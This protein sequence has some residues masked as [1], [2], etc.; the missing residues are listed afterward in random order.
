MSKRKICFLVIML[1]IINIFVIP[2]KSYGEPT[3]FITKKKIK[4][5]NIDKVFTI[6]FSVE[7][8]LS[9]VNNKYF[10]VTDDKGHV[11]NALVKLDPKDKRI[12]TVE[13][14]A[15]YK[16]GKT[17]TITVGKGVKSVDGE[18]LPHGIKIPFET[19]NFYAGLPAE[20]GLIIIGNEAYSIEYIA[21]NTSKKNEILKGNYKVFYIDDYMK[22]KIKDVLGFGYVDGT[23]LPPEY[24]FRKPLIYIDPNGERIQYIWDSDE[25]EFKRVDPEIKI[26]TTINAKDPS[27]KVI[28]VKVK[29]VRWLEGVEYFKTGKSSSYYKIDEAM[30]FSSPDSN[31]KIT[32]FSGSMTKIA[33]AEFSSYLEGTFVRK[34]K[35]FDQ[36]GEGNS[37]GNIVNN[38]YVASD[39]NGYIFYNN[40][41]DK[42]R[43]Y[44][45]DTNGLFHGVISDDFA[46]YINVV[47][48]WIYYSNY[49]DKAKL[50]RM[51]V[52]G[53]YK[54]KLNDE[55]SAFITIVGDYVYYSNYSD[56][57]RITRIRKDGSDATEDNKGNK[58]GHPLS[59]NVRDEAFFLN[60][61]GEW[62]YYSNINDHHRV[63]AVNTSGTYRK[64][65]SDEGASSIQVVDDWIYYTNNKG[66]LRK[67][68]SDGSKETQDLN[69]V[70]SKFERGYFFN[71]VDDWIYYSNAKDSNRLY[72][73]KTDG[74]QNTRLTF[75]P[76]TYINIAYNTIYF[77]SK[78]DMFTVPIDTNGKIKPVEVKKVVS[79][80]KVVQVDD[81]NILVPYEQVNET[82]EW[83]ENEHLPTKVTGIMSDNRIQQIVVQWDKKDVK[84]RDGV[85]TYRGKLIGYNQ[86]I[87]LTM[88]IPSEMLN[89][90]T[91][92]AIYNNAGAR[93][94]HIEVYSLPVK[95]DEV[96]NP[97]KLQEGDI[98]NLYADKDL[99]K[100]LR[101]T[102]VARYGIHNKGIFQ[103]VDLD[104]YGT[105][106]YYI[107]IKRH[108]KAESQGTKF[109]V[110]EAPVITNSIHK[111]V[112]DIDD[113]GL[114]IDGRDFFIEEMRV[115]NN[116]AVI[117][118]YIY[119]T[120]KGAQLKLQADDI[121]PFD[122]KKVSGNSWIG[123][124]YQDETVEDKVMMNIDSFGNLLLGTDYDLFL[125]SRYTDKGSADNRGQSPLILGWAVSEPGTI[126]VTSEELPY[127]PGLKTETK[128]Y[129]ETVTL[130][131]TPKPGEVAY[132]VPV[133]ESK[134]EEPGYG[135]NKGYK[136][137]ID[138]TWLKD[139][140][141]WLYDAKT[142]LK[143][144]G[145]WPFKDGHPAVENG[146]ITKL[147]GDG[148]T[149]IM[150]VPTGFIYSPEG[151]LEKINSKF[152]AP[153][154]KYKLVIIN[155]IGV[156]AVS[157]G[158]LTVDNK[159]PV[160]IQDFIDG[161]NK[162]IKSGEPIRFQS[163]Y[164]NADI[165]ISYQLDNLTTIEQLEDAVRIKAAYKFSILSGV[166]TLLPSNA[167]KPDTQ[168]DH[169][170]YK[171]MIADK[172]GNLR[173]VALIS[174]YVD[175]SEL[176]QIIEDATVA[177]AS[178]NVL[179][180]EVDLLKEK[181]EEAQTMLDKINSP[182]RT[183]IVTQSEIDKNVRDFRNLLIQLGVPHKND[184]LK[185]YEQIELTKNFLK[186]LRFFNNHSAQVNVNEIDQDIWLPTE[187]GYKTDYNFTI[188]WEVKDEGAVAKYVE[189]QGNNIG[190][191]YRP[192]GENP[193]DK[194][195]LV[196]KATI[197]NESGPLP[198]DVTHF[199]TIKAKKFITSVTVPLSNRAVISSRGVN[200][201]SEGDIDVKVFDTDANMFTDSITYDGITYN[202]D[203]KRNSN[204]IDWDVIV[205]TSGA[206]AG[207]LTG[208]TRNI[209]I[210]I[211]G[212]I[213][214]KQ[215]KLRIP[216]DGSDAVIM[217]Y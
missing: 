117:D 42:N 77:V 15:N 9:T 119:L 177:I 31:E 161:D 53:S 210:T 71:V 50:Y 58:H 156:S 167:I 211:N 124:R 215:V 90:T 145:P 116:K 108:G 28:M 180:L 52:D 131:V 126:A 120:S 96:N 61:V 97:P 57:G 139:A 198:G 129:G 151:D 21:N 10:Q 83:L 143:Q 44:K 114:G 166:T 56:N 164:E 12:V 130:G 73:I 112:R 32:L 217:G 72:K 104:R 16:Q 173:E 122:S 64:R 136:D 105:K 189:T 134:F 34:L 179:E 214:N 138:E 67:V 205:L 33:E 5:V 78:G 92:I 22:N 87:E 121:I 107:S 101:T 84:I 113:E 25:S 47:D 123:R 200:I 1:I 37:A 188:K 175:T 172:V 30:I 155:D 128:K 88:R 209:Q 191:I 135:G 106:E 137:Y 196:L 195:G 54:Q 89:E 216:A 152:Y 40:T 4:N 153:N 51:K 159:P 13:S 118:N 187:F 14:Q 49:R 154:I 146:Y 80:K 99:T 41:G 111:P 163:K 190:T 69:S 18:Y 7:L 26:Q 170:N 158:T 100:L 48:E 62:I 192:S 132:L 79:D 149:R 213:M 2:Q 8:D 23:K 148:S 46:Q 81:I 98:L 133:W 127:D 86:F 95:N 93:N 203:V 91:T 75:E 60:Y 186:K 43:L 76:V 207:A 171:I 102:V 181:L 194:S 142:W 174:V 65:L 183:D 201:D 168:K 85:R 59:N 157:N 3:T 150:P 125:V 162:Y 17:Y 144:N 206:D 202:F 29:E 141:T 199:I 36:K 110:G 176:E 19:K 185:I 38:G 35:L 147:E 6:K 160:V 193:D 45:Y 115:T 184:D 63:Y 24:N 20:E 103:S 140:K 70:V 66:E 11:V 94:G 39:E 178:G 55:Y 68:R 208:E 165:Y 169:L 182:Y 212:V 27:K 74:T 109:T 82:I 197:M 204:G